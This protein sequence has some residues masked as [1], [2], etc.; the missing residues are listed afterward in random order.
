MESGVRSLDL[1]PAFLE[2]EGRRGPGNA[3]AVHA[4]EVEC[5]KAAIAIYVGVYGLGSFGSLVFVPSDD[6]LA[7]FT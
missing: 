6:G 2:F 4:V 7:L 3:L 5:K 1:R